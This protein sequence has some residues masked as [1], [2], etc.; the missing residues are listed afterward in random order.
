[1]SQM[2]KIPKKQDIGE[3]I[4]FQY[5][6]MS[7]LKKNCNS[8]RRRRKSI[9]INFKKYN[10]WILYLCF[11]VFYTLLFQIQ[12]KVFF[13][14]LFVIFFFLGRLLRFF[15]LSHKNRSCSQIR[16]NMFDLEKGEKFPYVNIQS[17]I[18]FIFFSL[19]FFWWRNSD[20]KK[21]KMHME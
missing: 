12:P 10:N 9:P 14:C 4:V 19:L 2:W 3:N 13:R 5:M 18:Y 15:L 21:V 8:R 16:I 1:M 7:C 20:E 6:Q 11:N 17:E